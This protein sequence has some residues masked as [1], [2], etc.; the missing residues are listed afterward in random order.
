MTTVAQLLNTLNTLRAV[1][2][3]APLKNWKDS[4]AKLEAAIV[5]LDPPVGG[6]SK[7]N[8]VVAK[9]IHQDG[10][11]VEVVKTKPSAKGKAEPASFADFCAKHGLNQKV[12]RAKLRK[13]GVGKTNGHYVINAAVTKALINK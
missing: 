3:M 11:L 5:K 2:G 13:A 10:E 9:A 4:R 7:D 1:K 8:A 6:H 12:A